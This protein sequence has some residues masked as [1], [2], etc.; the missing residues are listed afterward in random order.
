MGYNAWNRL[1]AI[2]QREIRVSALL[3][4]PAEP[5]TTAKIH[6]RLLLSTLRDSFLGDL[7]L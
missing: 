5:I 2:K 6:E 1:N 4:I 7:Q 3:Q